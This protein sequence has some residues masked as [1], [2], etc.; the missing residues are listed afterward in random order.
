M[1]YCILKHLLPVLLT[2]LYDLNNSFTR[3]LVSLREEQRKTYVLLDIF[4]KKS[5]FL[6]V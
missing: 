5:H 1:Y 2:F 3:M 4:S 6:H